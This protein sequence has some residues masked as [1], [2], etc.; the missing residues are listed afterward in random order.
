MLEIIQ[1]LK[2]FYIKLGQVGATRADFLPPQYLNVVTTLQD[3]VPCENFATVKKVLERNFQKPLEE[4]FEWIEEQPLGSASIGQVHKAKLRASGEIVAVKVM[5]PGVETIFRGDIAT[6][7]RFCRLAQPEHLPGLI[8]IEKQFLTEFD[9][10]KEAQNL[11]KVGKNMEIWSHKVVVPKPIWS[12]QD[13]LIMTY[14]PGIKLVDGLKQHFEAIAKRKGITLDELKK[15]MEEKEARGE[16]IEGPSRKQLEKYHN[17]LKWQNTIQNLLHILYAW[18]LQPLIGGKSLV[19]EDSNKVALLNTAAIVEDLME[20]HGYQILV[21]GCF[22]GD[23][24]PGNILLTEDG[25]LGLIDYGQVKEITPKQRHKLARLILVLSE[26]NKEEIVRTYCE[27]GFRT[28]NMNSDVIY[29]HCKAIFDNDHRDNLGTNIQLYIEKLQ[30]L[31]PVVAMPNE[32]LMAGRVAVLLRGLAYALK[33][34]HMSK[35][36]E[37]LAK[38]V[39]K[40]TDSELKSV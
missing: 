20:V 18:T 34:P 24:H 4:V 2:G 16:K 28:K 17:Y 9:Y 8:E 37:G 23:P 3:A 35:Q 25:K 22:N 12:S 30:K 11:A 39:L 19:Q 38:E 32:Y 40:E 31:D 36:W 6:M 5:Y 1:H 33:Y 26:D 14:I 15:Q 21:N 10:R 13:V 7:K 29:R 27:M